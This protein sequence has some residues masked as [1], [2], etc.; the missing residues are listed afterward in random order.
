[1]QESKLLS[2]EKTIEKLLQDFYYLQEQYA[3][4]LKNLES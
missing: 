1:M 4:Q 3:I 2:Q